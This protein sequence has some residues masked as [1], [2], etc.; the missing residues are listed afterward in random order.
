[1]IRVTKKDALKAK[2]LP[3]GWQVCEVV[4]HYTKPAKESGA[5]VHYYELEVIEGQYKDVPLNEY[6]ISENAIGIG[7]NFFVACGMD[8]NEW[9]K[10]EKGEEFEFDEEFPVGKKL[11]VHVKPEVFGNRTLNKAADFM[12]MPASYVSA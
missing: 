10:A 7:K 1:M 5:T 11:R 8:K 6:T 4:R 12:S 9:E 2:V 3:A